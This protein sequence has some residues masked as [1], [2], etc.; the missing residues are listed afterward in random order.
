MSG[1]I[2]DIGQLRE[3]L[4]V[5]NILTERCFNSCIDNFNGRAPSNAEDSCLS[6]CIDKYMR[7]NRRLM[8]VFAEV[9]PQIL[10][11]QGAPAPSTAIISAD[12]AVKKEQ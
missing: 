6:K 7:V 4:S 10:F 5:Y 3:F 12:S 2:G 9:A 1:A 8:I 11:K